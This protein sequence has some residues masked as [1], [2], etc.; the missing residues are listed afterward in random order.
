MLCL[1]MPLFVAAALL[2]A[3]VP[4][5]ALCLAAALFS[6]RV[7]VG[8]TV[9]SALD[10]VLVWLAC[11]HAGRGVGSTL[12]NAHGRHCLS[13]CGPFASLT[14]CSDVSGAGQEQSPLFWSVSRLGYVCSAC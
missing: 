8:V 2:G 10:A 13:V 4:A 3:R 9:V 7:F 14:V 6:V 1:D 11:A 5:A 12:H